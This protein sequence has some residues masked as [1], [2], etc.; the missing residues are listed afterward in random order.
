[1][2][3][4][5]VQ[6]YRVDVR[7]AQVVRTYRYGKGRHQGGDDQTYRD[8]HPFPVLVLPVFGEGVSVVRL[9]SGGVPQA[10]RVLYPPAYLREVFLL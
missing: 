10:N 5:V 8:E 4:Y 2:T 6:Y 9:L 7:Y 3:S 1:M